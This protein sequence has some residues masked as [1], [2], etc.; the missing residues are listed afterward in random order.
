LVSS[1]VRLHT[2]GWPTSDAFTQYS[3]DDHT[4]VFTRSTVFLKASL[5]VLWTISWRSLQIEIYHGRAVA[6][7]LL[8]LWT[9][10]R[11]ATVTMTRESCFQLP[12]MYS[13]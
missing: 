1:A 10:K 4:T 8:A 7:V 5:I 3:L 9:T 6:I 13:T 2:S 12:A 11:V